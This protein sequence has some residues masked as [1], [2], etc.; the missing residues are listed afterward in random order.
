VVLADDGIGI[1]DATIHP[2]VK[3][4]VSAYA[5]ASIGN[6]GPWTFAKAGVE[7]TGTVT[8]DFI[9][10]YTDGHWTYDAPGSLAFSGNLYW[11]AIFGMFNGGLDLFNWQVAS[12][13]FIDGTGS[14]QAQT[15]L[16]A[17]TKTGPPAFEIREG[18]HFAITGEEWEDKGWSGNDNDGV[19]ESREH[20]RL[21]VH[22]TSLFAAKVA[23][24]S[25]RGDN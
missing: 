22:L 16:P 9:A 24:H 2:S 21:R 17:P 12:W 14:E 13:N 6:L 20:P 8:Q 15:S 25:V 11:E 1:S 10:K 3:A 23:V 5:E 18:N 19:I 4:G 7:A